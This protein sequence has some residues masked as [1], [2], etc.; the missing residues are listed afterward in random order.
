MSERRKRHKWKRWIAGWMAVLVLLQGVALEELYVQAA[1][2]EL[3]QA[4]EAEPSVEDNDTEVIPEDAALPL[5]EGGEAQPEEE[6]AAPEV[7]E[8]QTEDQTN[9]SDEMTPPAVSEEAPDTVLPEPE[10]V[11]AAEEEQQEPS[12]PEKPEEELQEPLQPETSQDQPQETEEKSSA[13]EEGIVLDKMDGDH[14]MEIG[15]AHV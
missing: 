13:G 11:L 8:E 9:P 14:H 1:E 12:Q 3:S 15:R 2:P 5:P 10:D 6:T 4:A 7:T